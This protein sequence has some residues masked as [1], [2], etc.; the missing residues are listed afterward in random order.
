MNTKVIRWLGLI[1]MLILG[2]VGLTTAAPA[3]TPAA[4]MYTNLNAPSAAS[5][6]TDPNNLCVSLSGDPA[7]NCVTTRITYLKFSLAGLA[8][9]R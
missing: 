9:E 8:P 4:D 7:G 6:Q 3:A 5:G 1:L 2:I